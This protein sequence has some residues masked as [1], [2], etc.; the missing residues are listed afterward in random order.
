MPAIP[1]IKDKASDLG[2]KDITDKD[3]WIEAKKIIDARLCRPLFCPGPNSM[4]LLTTKA[5]AVVSAWWEE[6]VNYYVKPPILDLFVEESRFEGKGFKMIAHIGKY[7]N[8]SST[9]NSRRHIFDLIDIKQAQDKSVITLKASPAYFPAS[10]WGASPLIQHC[11]WASCFTPFD[12]P[13]T[14]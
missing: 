14:G 11:R 8:P 1:T 13:T 12:P 2:C 9:V 4:I 7:F 6:N 3:S 10:T 5:Y